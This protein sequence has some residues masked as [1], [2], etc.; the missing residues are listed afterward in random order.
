MRIIQSMI[1]CFGMALVFLVM[2]IGTAAGE[3][4]VP[5][6]QG[7]TIQAAVNNA[8]DGDTII[9]SSG[10]YIENVD[11]SQANI[12]IE[13]EFGP[14]FTI[15]QANNSND[16][17]F[18]V[19][20][21]NVTING[22]NATGATGLGISGIYL[23][24]VQN[25]VIS[26]N[27]LS[28]N[29]FGLYLFSFCDNNTLS[30]NTANSNNRGGIYLY[31]FCNNNTLTNNTASDNTWRGI[32]ILESSNNLLSN[33]TANSNNGNGILLHQSSNSNTLTNNT[34]NSNY[35]HG[36][37]L[38]YSSNNEL[39]N[40]TASNNDNGIFL[41]SSSNNTLSNNTASNNDDGIFL[42]SS[43]NNTLS[44][45]T[46]S[47][48]DYGIRLYD[49]SNNTIYNN[50][51]NNTDNAGFGGTNTGNVW[52]TTKT[53]GINI[54]SGPFLGGNYWSDY[55]GVDANGDGIGDSI[56]TINGDIDYLPLCL[57][58]I[59][60]TENLKEYVNGLDEE[61]ADT[62][63]KHVLNVKLDNV[64]DKL[65]KGDDGKAIKKLEDFI[66]FVG[67]MVIE[68]RLDGTQAENLITE[69]NRII[70]IIQNSEG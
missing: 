61:Y 50:Y 51:F 15:V 3:I 16:H 7:P 41:F 11:V 40:N 30:N 34:A 68:G 33:N 22:F 48:N 10:T 57:I 66:E 37:Y 4:Y 21:D 58:P 67:E 47:N 35:W 55:V 53:L 26:D 23:D 63:T 54:V 32:Y 62:S 17:V 28:N 1:I 42:Y 20:A 31:S 64:I 70:G 36:I 5:S 38:L 27:N 6:A 29:W 24:G 45:N 8:T 56:H 14:D 13:S 25:N 18:H 12:T 65:D 43:S 44:N 59:K 2:T 46:A 69:A 39:S 19:T 52:N 49:S 9:V 60:E